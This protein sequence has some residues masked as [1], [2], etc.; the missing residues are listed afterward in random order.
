MDLKVYE[1]S[2]VELAALAKKLPTGRL[3]ANGK[4][5][6]PNVRQSLYSELVATLAAEPGKV[7]PSAKIKS[8]RSRPAC[9]PSSTPG[10]SSVRRGSRSTT[11]RGSSRCGTP[12]STTARSRKAKSSVTS[13]SAPARRESRPTSRFAANC[14]SNPTPRRAPPSRWRGTPPRRSRASRSPA[15]TGTSRTSP[16]RSRWI[17]RTSSSRDPRPTSRR[18]TSTPGCCFRSCGR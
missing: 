18:S 15:S 9:P 7:S 17:I 14:R 10:S 8:C 13:T 6:V 2:T 3:Y 5:F 4:A 11:T 16:S 1:A 12:R